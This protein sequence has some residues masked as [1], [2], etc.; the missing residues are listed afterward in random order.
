MNRSVGGYPTVLYPQFALRAT[1]DSLSWDFVLKHLMTDPRFRSCVYQL[2]D[3]SRPSRIDHT[4]LIKDP[5]S[6]PL[7]LPPQPENMFRRK[8][9][10]GLPDLVKNKDLMAVFSTVDLPTLS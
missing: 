9:K 8:L 6:I 1:Q 4:Q 7:N 2:L 5:S 10:E 3:I